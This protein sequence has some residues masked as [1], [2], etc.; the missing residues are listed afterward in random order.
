MRKTSY[1]SS[2]TRTASYSAFPGGLNLRLPPENIADGELSQA[3]NVTFSDTTGRLKT[4]PGLGEAAAAFED[5]IDAMFWHDGALFLAA[6]GYLYRYDLRDV[7]EC[8]K[9]SGSGVPAF[10]DFGDDLYIASGGALQRWASGPDGDVLSVVE[11]APSRAAGVYSRAGRLFV[12]CDGSDSLYCSAVGDALDWA[13]PDA[14]QADTD[15]SPQE[16]QIGYKV[17]GSIISAVPLQRDVVVFKEE[18]IFRLS[19]EYPDWGVL[20]LPRHERLCGA[21]A[22]VSASGALYYLEESGGLRAMRADDTYFELSALD[23][24]PR[25]NGW[26]RQNMRRRECFLAHIRAWNILLVGLGGTRAATVY[27]GLG[28]Q[29]GY[30]A[31][32][33]DFPAGI[34]AVCE[35]GG[36][37][38]AAVG[39]SVY[40]LSEK[41][42]LDAGA[43]ISASFSTRREAGYD[44]FF[45][46]GLYLNAGK[47]PRTPK[48]G[49]MSVKCS[50]TELISVT[51]GHD[52]GAEVYANDTLLYGCTDDVY[53]EPRERTEVRDRNVFRSRELIFTFASASSFELAQF[54]ARFVAVGGGVR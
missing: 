3:R 34:T 26:I 48:R 17:A 33:W 38:F 40:F 29:G 47:E 11:G 50:D 4:R 13:V 14:S 45:L 30:P 32:L 28:T 36:Y 46:K 52:A 41:N 43:P 6:G 39:K 10:A 8:G 21:G 12:W 27:L 37:V 16:V 18:G 5:A 1:H 9:L 31:L 2:E 19:G 7:T 35:G 23:A 44:S 51:L 22:A 15:A 24:L 49:P 42:F 53:C 25:M 54:D 20:E